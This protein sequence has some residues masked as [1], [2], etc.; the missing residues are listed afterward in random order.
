VHPF[1]DGNGR[2][3]RMAK[4]WMLMYKLCPPIFIS[5]S[6]E[7]KEYVQALEKSFLYLDKGNYV[8]NEQIE[9]FF[10][11]ELDRLIKNTSDVYNTVA[12]L[13]NKR[14]KKTTIAK[15]N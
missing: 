4:N 7:K 5:D 12:N 11:Q 9:L 1:S 10:E 13:G 8:W 6:I 3:T 2:T 14:I 15:K